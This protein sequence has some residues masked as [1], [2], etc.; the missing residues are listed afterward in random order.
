MTEQ[1]L[2]KQLCE[3]FMVLNN[4]VDYGL[5]LD[6]TIERIH[7]LIHRWERERGNTDTE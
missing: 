2:L 1:E 5:E 7:E 3:L 4:D 6:D